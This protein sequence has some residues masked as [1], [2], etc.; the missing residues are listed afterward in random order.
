MDRNLL[1]IVLIATLPSMAFAGHGTIHET[2][3]Q[4]V[5]EYE[6]DTNEVNAA[7]IIKAK[8]E[9]LR[10]QEEQHNA[11]EAARIQIMAENSA[12]RKQESR[13]KGED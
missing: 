6:G 10:E 11:D 9:T 13:A 2:E 7:N 3:S 1:I 5:V 12:K 8:E 4:I